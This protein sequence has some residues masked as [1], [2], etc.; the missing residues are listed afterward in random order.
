MGFSVGYSDFPVG[1]RWVSAIFRWVD[2]GFPLLGHFLEKIGVVDFPSGETTLC[3]ENPPSLRRIHSLFGESTTCGR[4]SIRR[5]ENPQTCQRIH[6]LT[7]ETTTRP[8]NHRM[9]GES[10]IVAE[11][12]Q[13][14]RKI[15]NRNRKSTINKKALPF[16]HRPFSPVFAGTK[17]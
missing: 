4:K 14:P 3:P 5:V 13:P 6:N 11:N 9:P 8:E 7:G 16:R 1:W 2:G 17:L 12:P 15:H 10:T